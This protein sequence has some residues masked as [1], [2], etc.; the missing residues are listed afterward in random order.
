MNQIASS[1][2]DNVLHDLLGEELY[3]EYFTNC[4]SDYTHTDDLGVSA[5]ASLE[6]GGAVCNL[7]LESIL[8][9]VSDQF[10]HS[11]ITSTNE[12]KASTGQRFATP[13]LKVMKKL[14]K[15]EELE[16]QRRLR[17]ILDTVWRYGTNGAAIGT[18]LWTMNTLLKISRPW[19]TAVCN[20]G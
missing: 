5:H 3:R 14:R 18:R 15:L 4:V 11:C 10:E 13:L 19:T 20:I 16:S 2:F 1:D 12:A 7:D 17:L 8:L 6:G 9:E